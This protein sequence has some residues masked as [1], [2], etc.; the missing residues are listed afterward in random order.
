MSVRRYN[1]RSNA[2]ASQVGGMMMAGSPPQVVAGDTVE[3]ARVR[4]RI[5]VY[6]ICVLFVLLVLV[7]WYFADI[8]WSLSKAI[9]PILQGLP[10][11]AVWFGALGGIVIGLKAIYDHGP[12]DWQNLYNLWHIGRP[13]SGG[14]AGGVTYLFLLA[15]SKNQP[16]GPVVLAAAFILGTQDKRFFN[17]LFQ[18]A[19][20]VVNVPGD[21]QD[22]ALSITEVHP[23]QGTQGTELT[24][25]G[26]GFD[27][28][29]VVQLGGRRLEEVVVNQD[30]TSI[31]GIV[32]MGT[33]QVDLLVINPD[34]TARSFSPAF[35]YQMVSPTR[36]DFSPQKVQ[37][38][39]AERTVTF[40]NT[41]A[42]NLTI[43]QVTIAGTDMASFTV[44]RDG[45][46]GVNLG[47]G[48]TC[49]VGIQFAPG[50]PGG[51]KAATLTIKPATGGQ[52]QIPLT[53]TATE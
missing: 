39:S 9:P 4:R 46:S 50:S 29:A 26:Q 20:L 2:I 7:W 43:D 40:T 33:G 24:I 5:F 22:T 23:A 31:T 15:T 6:D 45:C 14:V 52:A 30:G 19:R 25:L 18:I 44:V 8:P 42:A 35:S 10:A 47:P 49:T 36:L 38:S 34:G 48:G 11:Y 21:Q 27:A 53:G 13:F 16:L 28:G 1:A 17:F 3:N 37:T 41:G 32:P 51:D 12:N